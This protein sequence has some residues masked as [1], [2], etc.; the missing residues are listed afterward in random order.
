V[1]DSTRITGYCK[2]TRTLTQI[3]LRISS[4]CGLTTPPWPGYWVSRSWKSD[5]LLGSASPGVQLCVR[6]SSGAKANQRRSNLSRTMPRGMCS[7]LEV[8]KIGRQPEDTSHRCCRREWLGSCHPEEVAGGW[9]RREADTTG[10]TTPW[11]EGHVWRQSHR[12]KLLG[13]IELSGDTAC[14]SSNV[15]RPMEG[16]RQTDSPSTEQNESTGRIPWRT[17][18]RT[19]R[20]Q[21]DSR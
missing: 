8:R 5:S 12:Q 9:P 1:R 10:W 19:P 17:F 14:C 6:I 11:L 21:Q 15:S 16:T 20:W 4:I 13:P 18:G 3:S 7:L 2:D